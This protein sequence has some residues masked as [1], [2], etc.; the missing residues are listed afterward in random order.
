MQI[1]WWTLF[2]QTVNFLILVWLLQRFL[3]RPVLAIIDRRRKETDG[4]IDAAKQAREEAEKERQDL[5][6]QRKAIGHERET[7]LADAKQDA[8][9]VRKSLIAEAHDQ[10]ERMLTEARAQ[11]AR[12]REDAA[13][14]LHRHAAAIAVGLA[15][16]V[17]QA[18]ADEN[19]DDAFF[20]AAIASLDT[21]S[22]EER[23]SLRQAI[24]QAD[25]EVPSLHMVTARPLGAEQKARYRDALAKVVGHE[26]AISFAVDDGLIAGLE[27]HLPHTI[28][29]HSVRSTLDQAAQEID[30]DAAPRT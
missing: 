14:E 23:D 4:L 15:G 10:T 22:Q 28:V 1:D 3:Y 29:H 9:D 6:D 8:D 25:T 12:E 11:L 7:V 2:F 19:L 24:E 30:D 21:L 17:L 5:I 26:P 20:N 16:H 27:L 13:I 18:V